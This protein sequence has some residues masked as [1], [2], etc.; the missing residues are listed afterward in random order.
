MGYTE[1]LSRDL[2]PENI[3]GVTNTSGKGKGDIRWKLA[4]F[5]VAK[6]LNSD[7][8]GKFYGST[9]CG[10]PLYMAPEVLRGMLVYQNQV[11][12]TKAHYEPSADIWSLGR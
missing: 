2:K 3:L 8:L 12:P 9:V 6:L 1:F 11:I 10:T 7:G 4:D 5:G